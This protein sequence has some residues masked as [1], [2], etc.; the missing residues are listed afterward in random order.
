MSETANAAAD[1][2]ATMVTF[3]EESGKTFKVKLP[4]GEMREVPA[5]TPVKTLIP[6][7][8]AGGLPVVAIRFNNK[9]ASLQRPVDRDGEIALVDLLSRD[10]GLIYRR[11]VTFLLIRAVHDLFPD[12]KVYINHS[13][14]NGYYGEMYHEMSGHTGPQ[15]LAESDLVRIKARMRELVDADEPFIRKEMPVKDAIELFASRG[16]EDK[17]QLLRYRTDDVISVYEFG[18]MVNHFYGQLAPSSGFLQDFDLVTCT[19]GFVLQF[20]GHG[21]PGI[22]PSYKHEDRLFAVYQEYEKW[23]RILGVRSVAHLN[24]LIDTKKINEYVLIAEA[25]Q[26][27]KLARL[28]D[29]IAEHPRQP[30]IVLLSGPSS[31]GKTTTVKRLAIQLRVNGLQPL[32]IGL[33]DFFVERERTPRDERGEF[34]FEN[35]K[36]IDVPLLQDCVRRLLRGEETM[37]PKFDFILG[38]PVPGH[39]VQLLPGQH[40]ILE[41][42]HGLN[43]E[44]LPELPDGLKFKIYIS[45][46][47]HLNIDD[48]N[49]TASSDTRLIRRLVRDSRYRGYDGLAT[50]SRWPSVRRG[51]ERNIFPYQ[52]EADYIFNSS[53]PYEVCVLK[54]FALPLLQAVPR[55]NAIYAEA[56]RL[57]KFMSYFRDIK[58]DIVPRH[59]LLREFI[60]GSSFKY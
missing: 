4:N 6:E 32:V 42:I 15:L 26:E 23:S 37:I 45:P 56:A 20:P 14:N 34:D 40:L 16:M 30:R 60:G 43:P 39:L 57:A 46:L 33:D 48:H 17:V 1:L 36:A 49:R 12:L 22:M 10:G 21:L 52:N 19:P 41:G 55:D 2:A 44:L 24:G 25:L 47:T 11:S 38:K 59:S 28:A 50:L 51:E 29:T 58:A 53:L 7:K 3:P 35:F 13:L 8:S 9:I 27:K 5:G 54:E 31:S 18:P